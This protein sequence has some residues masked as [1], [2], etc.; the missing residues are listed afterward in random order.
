MNIKPI[1]TAKD[2]KA[3]L[4]EVSKLM[5]TDPDIVTLK[6][7]RLDQLVTLV[8]AYEAKH[9]PMALP[10]HLEAIKFR[11]EQQGLKPKD[12]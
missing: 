6:G 8:H 3:A 10:D 9:I 1:R 12:L 2:H 5:E 7:D 11:M 4:T